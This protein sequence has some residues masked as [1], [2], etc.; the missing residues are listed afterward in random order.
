MSLSIAA[1]DRLEAACAAAGFRV[2]VVVTDNRVRLVSAKRAHAGYELRVA[3]PVLA[4]GDAA[5]EA[6]VD[7][8]AGKSDG[9]ARLR[10]LIAQVPR[11]PRRSRETR[12]V[13]R[14]EHHDLRAISA[15]EERRYF[16]EMT[17]IPITWGPARRSRQTRR[18]IRLGSYDVRRAIVRIHRDLDH[19]RVP[20]W[21]I[22]FVVYHELL[23]HVMR[24][25][26]GGPL[27]HHTREFRA[28]E[29]RHHLYRESLGWERT[30]LPLLLSGRL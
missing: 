3:A 25:P 2:S 16:P 22:G 6:L 29:A 10:A 24:A 11:G 5:E 14:G 23:H 12:I 7:W 28:R 15:A 18:S 9:R 1:A 27:R 17:P 21:F 30:H 19:P 8:L 26:D 4:L 13:T 20:A